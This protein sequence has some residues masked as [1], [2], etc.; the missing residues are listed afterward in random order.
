[1]A[2]ARLESIAIENPVLAGLAQGVP[3]DQAYIMDIILPPVTVNSESFSYREFTGDALVKEDDDLRAVGGESNE[4]KFDLA[5]RTGTLNEH[6][7]KTILDP[8]EIEAAERGGNVLDLRAMASAIV[9]GKILVG[10]EYRGA[11]TVTST[12]SYAAGHTIN[13]VDWANDDIRADV[14]V[15]RNTVKGKIGIAPMNLALGQAT[16]DALF[17]NAIV[18]GDIRP[19]GGL[20]D[21]SDLARYLGVNRIDVGSAVYRNSAG[22]AFDIWD[23]VAILYYSTNSPA[24]INPSFG[25]TFTMPY[26]N[27]TLD[28]MV[29]QAVDIEGRE[30]I[31]YKQRYLHTIV[32]NTAA[33]LWTDTAPA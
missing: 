17:S 20:F 23:D 1:M 2:D 21:N 18:K 19:I 31:F 11:V 14:A 8:R 29:R 9:R 3:T 16:L 6:S 27:G 30:Y 26:N 12:G 25:Y 7:L 32:Q 15:R 13:T 24:S 5:K 28:G 10:R 33:F 4:V 22:A